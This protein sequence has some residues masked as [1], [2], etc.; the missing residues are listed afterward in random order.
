MARWAK[1]S[2]AVAVTALWLVACGPGG[3][4]GPGPDADAPLVNPLAFVGDEH[5]RLLACLADADPVA[6]NDLFDAMLA[7]G[8]DLRGEVDLD[9]LR[10]EFRT[11]GPKLPDWIAVLISS[12]FNPN[13]GMV[14]GGGFSAQEAEILTELGKILDKSESDEVSDAAAVAKDL[15]DLAALE[16]RALEQLGD[17]DSNLAKAVLA[18]VSIAQASLAYWSDIW[19]NE[20]ATF[21]ANG[22]KWW[23]VVAADV[24]G[25]IVG[26]VFGGGVGAVGLGTAASKIVGDLANGGGDGGGGGIA[27]P[28]GGIGEAHNELLACLRDADPGG[29][30]D[31]FD[32][33]VDACPLEGADDEFMAR[34]RRIILKDGGLRAS[35]E[36]LVET[37]IVGWDR[38]FS[39]EEYSEAQRRYLL[40]LGVIINGLEEGSRFDRAL[41][42]LQILEGRA[43]AELVDD[44]DA[45]VLMGLNIAVSSYLYWHDVDFVPPAAGPP[46][47]WHVVL[48]DV[49][50]GVV[51]GAFGGGVGAVGLG[52]AASK[53]VG[54]LGGN[55]P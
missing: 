30:S 25:G 21:S 10:A 18:G 35:A 48:A 28:G 40:E 17:S 45:A 51:G 42:A 15:G 33:M 6:G 31:P 50:G 47:W 44:G 8:L 20:D 39:A 49:A 53:I 13:P 29:E 24:A 23:Q 52:T 55:E 5:N 54:D 4:N 43:R 36:S 12:P 9:D 2:I 34:A 32:L 1:I 22:P 7:C 3:G 27:N 11:F 41:L 26:G 46:K 37:Y 14:S 38:A 19:L 16:Q